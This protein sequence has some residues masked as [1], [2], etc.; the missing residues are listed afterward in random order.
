[1]DLLTLLPFIIFGIIGVG[2]YGFYKHAVKHTDGTDD[3]QTADSG[4]KGLMSS[5]YATKLDQLLGL[6]EAEINQ[7]KNINS[8]T[9]SAAQ[10]GIVGAST[11]HP[12][13]GDGT[14]GRILRGIRLL[15]E[16]GTTGDTLKC[17]VINR[18][19]GDTIAV[20]DNIAKDATTGDFSLT[21][22]GVNLNIKASG[23]SG[24]CVYAIGQIYSNASGTDITAGVYPVSNDITIKAVASKTGV[25][26]DL[27]V[28]V[29]TGPINVH[30]FYITDA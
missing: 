21:A 1:M 18:W 22:T 28:L 11:T 7:L 8:T 9:I 20:T 16:N 2:S 29:D 24:N 23:L 10:W 27:T 30:I 5:V 19:N 14:A 17:T 26:Q 25:D 4:Q 6:L 15:I 13:G 3:I 12:I